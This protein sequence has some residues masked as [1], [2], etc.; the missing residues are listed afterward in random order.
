M[1]LHEI[2]QHGGLALPRIRKD[3]VEVFQRTTQLRKGRI[4]LDQRAH[5]GVA[6]GIAI[7]VA[8]GQEAAARKTRVRLIFVGQPPRD[9]D[10]VRVDLD[11]ACI[12]SKQ[13][14][15]DRDYARRTPTLEEARA[16]PAQAAQLTQHHVVIC[17]YERVPALLSNVDVERAG[18]LSALCD[19]P[20]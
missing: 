1:A 15:H 2:F 8:G 6:R 14:G 20:S 4:T 12:E 5:A 16:G 7:F 11:T 18:N 10:E 9:S 17:G 3:Y 13:I 19:K